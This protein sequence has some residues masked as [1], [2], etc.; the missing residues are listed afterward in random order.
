MNEMNLR[1]FKNTYGFFELW[2][3]ASMLV[4][5][6]KQQEKVSEKITLLLLNFEHDKV[7]SIKYD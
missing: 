5:F 4:M 2:P 6:L 1:K 3:A 7:R